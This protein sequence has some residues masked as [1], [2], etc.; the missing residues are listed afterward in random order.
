MNYI[1]NHVLHNLA[2]LA[3]NV[4]RNHHHSHQ[5]DANNIEHGDNPV[6]NDLNHHGFG[7]NH[8]V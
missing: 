3:H 1:T 8:R 2:Y 6:I 5:R 7:I 4:Q